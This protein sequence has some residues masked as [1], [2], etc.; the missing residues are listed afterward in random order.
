[1]HYTGFTYTTN[2]DVIRGV[3]ESNIPYN[4]SY[5]R[6]I[7]NELLGM[8]GYGSLRILGTINVK[9]NASS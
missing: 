7:K 4:A 2:N 8:Y 5:S 9:D 6:M 1:M 3:Q